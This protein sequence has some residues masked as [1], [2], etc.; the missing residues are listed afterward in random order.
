MVTV[1]TMTRLNMA[2]VWNSF[3]MATNCSLNVFQ[4]VCSRSSGKSS[5]M[6]RFSKS[7]CALIS[8]NSSS[9]SSWSSVSP[10]RLDSTLRASSSRPWWISQRGE[11]GMKIMPTKRMT[12]GASCRQMG[13]SHAASDWVSSVPPMKLVPLSIGEWVAQG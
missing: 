6:V 12:A 2:L 10:R 7:D 8:R 3:L 9:T 11:K 1:A 5:A 13:T 4:A